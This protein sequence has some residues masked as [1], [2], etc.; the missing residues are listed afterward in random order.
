VAKDLAIFDGGVKRFAAEWGRDFSRL[1]A[2]F[3]QR[4][5]DIIGNCFWPPDVVYSRRKIYAYKN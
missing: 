5:P 4:T 3:R 1:P 2:S